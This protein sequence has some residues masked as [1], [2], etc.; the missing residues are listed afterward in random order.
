MHKFKGSAFRS[1]ADYIYCIT[2]T[3]TVPVIRIDVKFSNFI[4]QLLHASIFF[5][6]RSFTVTNM[7]KKTYMLLPEKYN[8]ALGW[9]Q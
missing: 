1:K 4:C 6:N 3:N 2:R 7:Q 5:P 8:F 9:S